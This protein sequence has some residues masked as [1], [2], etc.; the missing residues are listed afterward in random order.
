MS[1]ARRPNPSERAMK[2]LRPTVLF[3]TLLLIGGTRA[4][5]CTVF[6]VFDGKLAMAGS[7]EDWADPNTQIWFVP[8]TKDNYGIVYFG[9][10][11]G[12]YPQGGVSRHELR[13]PGGGITQINPEDLYGL[14]QGGMNE[15]GLFFDGASTD[16]IQSPSSHEKK[17]Y[18]GRL[19]DL[20]LRKCATVKE[21][22]KL[23]DTYAFNSVQ[24]QWMFADKTGDS[25]I[26]EAGEVIVRKESNYQA[27][28]N[29]HQSKVEPEKVTCPRYKLVS[30]S[31]G[32]NKAVSLDVCRSLLKGTAQ[33]FTI[34]STI[35]DLTNGEIYVHHRRDFDR[36]VKV[37]LKQE[38]AKGERALRIANLLKP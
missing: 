6:F 25:V 2:S 4:H 33:P 36:T 32:E 31:L 14:P 34:Y 18:D 7:N 8:A 27:M 21:V 38:L 1:A 28:T 35:F 10:G 22:L 3:L 12:E 16:V 23:L 24:G 5:S 15:K 37:N 11:R 26:I 13:I 19:E 20:I 30:E 29:F 9:F 17:A